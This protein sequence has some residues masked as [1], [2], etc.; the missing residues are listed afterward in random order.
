MFSPDGR[1][2]AYV[3][4]ESGR[5]EVYMQPF[6]G[7]GGKRQISTEGGREPLWAKNGRELFYRDGEAFLSVSVETE[8]AFERGPATALF[9]DHYYVGSGQTWDISPDG[10]RFLMV[11]SEADPAEPLHLLAKAV[12]QPFDPA[13]LVD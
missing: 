1:W 4:D 13:L 2:L 12:S 5:D 9:A 10:R 3:S 7:P 8:G 11:K 6:P